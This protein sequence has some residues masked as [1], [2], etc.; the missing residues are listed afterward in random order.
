[1]QSGNPYEP[2]KTAPSQVT[3]KHALWRIFVSV[4]AATALFLIG[5]AVA[6]LGLAAVAKSDGYVGFA[7][8]RMA[9]ARNGSL[10]AIFCF[11]VACLIKRRYSIRWGTAVRDT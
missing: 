5:A 3:D 2:P 6:C 9:D 4:Y 11:A 8:D 1:M 10:A 7:R